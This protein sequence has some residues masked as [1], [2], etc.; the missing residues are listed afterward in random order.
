MYLLTA[1]I[2]SKEVI[3]LKEYHQGGHSKLIL[4]I[5]VC[6]F[7]ELKITPSEAQCD[8]FHE[9]SILLKFLH[10]SLMDFLCLFSSEDLFLMDNKHMTHLCTDVKWNILPLVSWWDC[11]QGAHRPPES[12]DFNNHKEIHAP[13][14]KDCLADTLN[15]TVNRHHVHSC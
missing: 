8:Q 9:M 4:H 3:C 1:K 13:D 11:P 12:H 7:Y 14:F 6:H 5:C 15:F 10:D 2:V